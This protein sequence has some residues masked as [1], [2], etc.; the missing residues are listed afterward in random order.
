MLNVAL[1]V[2]A[3]AFT[4]GLISNFRQ[5]GPLDLGELVVSVGGL[6]VVALLFYIKGK[7]NEES[8]N[9]AAK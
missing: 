7:R 8:K 5:T 3:F 2:A 6:L 9:G 1:A 4:M